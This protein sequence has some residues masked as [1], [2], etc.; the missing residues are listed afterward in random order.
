VQSVNGWD[1]VDVTGERIYWK[2]LHEACDKDRRRT[3]FMMRADQFSTTGD[4]LEATAWLLRNQP[5]LMV[6][7]NWHGLI[8]RVLYDTREFA[9]L[10]KQT[11]HLRGVENRDERNRLRYAEKINGA[12]V[13]TAVLDRDKK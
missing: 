2:I 12:A 4:L 7:S 13:I 8:Q 9:D 5:E 3:D 1:I 6:G 10:L 11:A